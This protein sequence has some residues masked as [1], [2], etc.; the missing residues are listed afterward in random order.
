MKP[1]HHDVCFLGALW[2]KSSI[3]SCWSDWV[4]AEVYSKTSLMKVNSFF[5]ENSALAD[6]RKVVVSE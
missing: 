3:K 5:Q 4:S 6:S 1:L 2:V